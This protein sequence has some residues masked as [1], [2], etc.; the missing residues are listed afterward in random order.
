MDRVVA[1]ESYLAALVL[2]WALILVARRWPLVRATCMAAGVLQCVALLVMGWVDVEWSPDVRDAPTGAVL[3]I[4][5][6]PIALAGYGGIAICIGMLL[7]VLAG[8][9]EPGEVAAWRPRLAVGAITAASLALVLAIVAGVIVRHQH[10]VRAERY[11]G[12]CEARYVHRRAVDVPGSIRY[13][14]RGG[15]TQPA[16][17]MCNAAGEDGAIDATGTIRRH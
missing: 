7:D 8:A 3:T 11:V 10:I 9:H 5:F 16:P 13:A 2:I 17:P 6:M 15:L 1:I 12:R 14:P 4:A